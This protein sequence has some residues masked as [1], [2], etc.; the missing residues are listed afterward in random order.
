[1]HIPRISPQDI[2]TDI[3]ESL[4]C[5][6]TETIDLYWLHRDDPKQP[7]A[8][9]LETLNNQVTKGKIRYFGC[10]NWRVQRIEE[11]MQYATDHGIAGFVG[12]QLMWSFAVPNLDALEAYPVRQDWECDPAQSGL[13]LSRSVQAGT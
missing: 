10:S 7:V 4:H 5:L 3:D 2:I 12:N 1:M 11:A 13:I 6:Q 9:I 8:A